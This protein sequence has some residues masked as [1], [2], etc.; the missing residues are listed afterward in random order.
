MDRSG[1]LIVADG[2]QRAVFYYPQL[3]FAH[4]ASLN[5]APVAPGQLTYFFRAGDPFSLGDFVS[6]S[7]PWPTV[8]NDVQVTIAGT[9]APIYLIINEGP[10]LA[11]QVPTNAPTT[12]TA[13]VLITHPSTG[14][15]CWC[16]ATNSMQQYNP[17]FFTANELGSGQVEATNGVVINTENS[18][19]SQ[20][21]RA[22]FSGTATIQFCLTGGGP[23]YRWS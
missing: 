14:E 15:I 5:S 20:W 16:A 9:A 12:G 7:Y 13:D 6:T 3:S 2:A 18:P 10:Y 11:I 17:G 21:S 22:R 4:A 23:F 19:N 1:N 8:A